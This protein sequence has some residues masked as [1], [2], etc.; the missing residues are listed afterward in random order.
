RDTFSALKNQDNSAPLRIQDLPQALRNRFVGVTGKLLLQVYPQK[1]VWQRQNQEEFIKALQKIDQNVTGTPVQLYYY[2]ELLKVSYE[3]AA[4]Y[5]LGAIIIMV[6]IH[7]RTLSSVALALLPVG[8]GTLWLGG[9]MGYLGV[10][11]NPAN[12]MT[13]PLVI[14]IG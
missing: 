8:I 5:A 11:L 14:G 3:Y 6:F 12:I 7:F 2:T 4:L 10:P 9:L 13:L 1:D